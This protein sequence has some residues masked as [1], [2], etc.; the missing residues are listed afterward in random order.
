MIH[1]ITG[2]ARSG[3]SSYAQK[4]AL[5]LSGSPVYVAT[6]NTMDD[7]NV[8]DKEFEDRINRHKADR[9]ERWTTLEEPL[10]IS[11]LPIDGRVAV[12]DCVTLWLTNFFFL[13]NQDIQASLDGL[14]KEIDELDKHPGTFFIVSNEIGMG[15][16]ADSEM[17]RKFVD[18]QG[19]A[20]QYI[21]SKASKVVFM[22]SGIPMI[23]KA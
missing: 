16:H 7:T 18:L 10:H 6:A 5:L 8:M 2:G 20:N 13:H 9:D 15:L 17:G 23:V 21:A 14:K 1:F 22:V 19:W 12:V 11:K 3:K 4:E